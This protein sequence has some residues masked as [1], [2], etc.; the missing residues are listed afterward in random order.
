MSDTHLALQEEFSSKYPAL[1]AGLANMIDRNTFI[2]IV[3]QLRTGRFIVVTQAVWDEAVKLAHEQNNPGLRYIESSRVGAPFDYESYV[4]EVHALDA[5]K[6][7]GFLVSWDR[8][9]LKLGGSVRINEALRALSG[10]DLNR[11][12]DDI[13]R[14]VD[15]AA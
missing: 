1:F 6:L 11:M 5:V 7:G 2:D 9:E 14:L 10:M 15:R 8:A 13:Y 3:E 4:E 12:V